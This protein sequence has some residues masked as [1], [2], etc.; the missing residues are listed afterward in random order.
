MI[1]RSEVTVEKTHRLVKWKK[2]IEEGIEAGYR[3]M[4]RVR[5]I[6]GDH[7]SSKH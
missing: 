3:K 2:G 7:K 5:P 1:K 4:G 6:K